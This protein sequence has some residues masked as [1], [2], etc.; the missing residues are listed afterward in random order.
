MDNL[1][2]VPMKKYKHLHRAAIV[3]PI[4][5]IVLVAALLVWVCGA[6][7]ELTADFVPN[8]GIW[9]C[10]ELG[11]ELDFDCELGDILTTLDG[12]K[13]LVDG[14]NPTRSM[15]VYTIG[16][17]ICK[18]VNGEAVYQ[19]QVGE[20]VYSFNHTRITGKHYTVYGEDGNKYIFV[21]R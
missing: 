11:L 15:S 9:Y 5:A 16:A 4:L 7:M 18:E 14:H 21:R 20:W 6:F 10:E 1:I 8:D 17:I 12:E 13:Y 2:V 3:V 19:Y